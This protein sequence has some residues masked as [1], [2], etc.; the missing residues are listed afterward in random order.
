MP[1]S[2][3][4]LVLMIVEAH[5]FMKL[6]LVGNFQVKSCVLD[7]TPLSLS[8]LFSGELVSEEV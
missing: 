2:L 5:N 8:V 7:F 3:D 6:F 4:V 1:L